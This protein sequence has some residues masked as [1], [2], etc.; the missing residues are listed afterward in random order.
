MEKLGA[1]AL[2]TR[3]RSGYNARLYRASI[4]GAETL[5]EK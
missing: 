4:V 5:F 3:S 1:T 2:A